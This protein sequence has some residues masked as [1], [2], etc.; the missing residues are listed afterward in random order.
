MTRTPVPLMC[1]DLLDT[2]NSE[3]SDKKN[4]TTNVVSVLEALAISL[5]G[6]PSQKNCVLQT[7]HILYAPTISRVL[8]NGKKDERVKVSLT[9]CN[10]TY[11]RVH[12][13]VH[14]Y[15]PGSSRIIRRVQLRNRSC[16]WFVQAYHLLKNHRT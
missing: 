4:L 15:L 12:A 16:G 9:F 1:V 14:M 3:N 5:Y 6:V 13:C 7:R 8:V 10:A 11:A 2:L